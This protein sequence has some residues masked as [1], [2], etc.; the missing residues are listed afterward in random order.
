MNNKN[1][2]VKALSYLALLIW[3]SEISICGYLEEMGSPQGWL[4]ILK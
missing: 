4:V 2:R 1:I 3:R